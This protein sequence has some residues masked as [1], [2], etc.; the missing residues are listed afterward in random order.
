M[1][2][3]I[4]EKKNFEANFFYGIRELFTLI[5]RVDINQDQIS[6]GGSK[7]YNVPFPFIKGIHTN[8]IFR[9]KSIIVDKGVSKLNGLL[10]EFLI[11]KRDILFVGIQSH[12]IGIFFSH[13]Q[14]ELGGG[15]LNW[16]KE[17]IAHSMGFG[18][19]GGQT[20]DIFETVWES[21]E[22]VDPHVF[23]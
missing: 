9:F 15:Q 21:P 8:S 12:F 20:E 17:G 19:H 22:K 16:I 4:R 5:G 14:L 2:K 3:F 23:V 10:S 18:F 13:G 11:G 1:S 6:E 7:L